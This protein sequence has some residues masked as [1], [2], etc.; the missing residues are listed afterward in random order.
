MA[1][2]L[3]SKSENDDPPLI[4]RLRPGEMEFFRNR[5]SL[6]LLFNI[7]TDSPQNQLSLSPG[8]GRRSPFHFEE[9]VPQSNGMVPRTSFGIS[10]DF[11]VT[12]YS[13]I[14]QPAASSLD[15]YLQPSAT[16]YE[17]HL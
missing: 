2:A 16:W 14:N 11:R 9:V 1:L 7:F 4:G 3:D 15:G 10:S 6:S 17:K 13:K 8:S 12:S 5:H